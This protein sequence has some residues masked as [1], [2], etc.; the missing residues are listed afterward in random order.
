MKKFLWFIAGF[1]ATNIIINLLRS[2]PS[3]AV[4]APP[5]PGTTRAHIDWSDYAKNK[6]STNLTFRHPW[7]PL[8]PPHFYRKVQ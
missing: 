7:V 6:L 2:Q 3:L 8:S 1:V 5:D 4:V